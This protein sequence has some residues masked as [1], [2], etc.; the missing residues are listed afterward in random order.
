VLLDVLHNVLHD[1]L[2]DVLLNVLWHDE[3]KKKINLIEKSCENL[4]S[5]ESLKHF[6]Q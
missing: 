3:K 5:R 4:E 6:F 1:V 2:H